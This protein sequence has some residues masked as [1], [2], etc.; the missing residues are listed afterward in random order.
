MIA[1]RVLTAAGAAALAAS[2]VY[3]FVYLYRWEWNRALMAAVL[4][5]AAEIAL[6]VGALLRR[7]G[8][9]SRRLDEASR[10]GERATLDEIRASAPPAHRHFAWLERRGGD[11]NVFIPVLL[12]AGVVAS[13]LA[14]VVERVARATV[15][16]GLERDLAVRLRPF[17]LPAGPV[18]AAPSP[19]RLGPPPAGPSRVAAVRRVVAG[20]ACAGLAVVGVDALAD[21]T[22]NRPDPLVR[23]AR[24]AI[25]LEVLNRDTDTLTSLDAARGLWGVCR[26]TLEHHAQQSSVSRSSRRLFVVEV[27]PALGE[28]DMR[29]IHGC[30]ED[31]L[32]DNVQAR[33]VAATLLRD[34]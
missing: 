21:L 17:E 33:V 13:A 1:R 34:R 16:P 9:L 27:R 11:L 23:D 3:V 24:T 18:L 25:V 28:H 19:V 4:F 20:A 26:G 6:A 5:V 32:L 15:R 10:G 30:F 12:G 14:W 2:G 22:Q 8:E 7:M 29:R 31:A